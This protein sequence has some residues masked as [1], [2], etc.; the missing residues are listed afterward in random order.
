VLALAPPGASI[1]HSILSF[2]S[3]EGAE[4]PL[5]QLKI[6]MNNQFI[7]MST[8][9]TDL[10]D[11]VDH[12]HFTALPSKNQACLYELSHEVQDYLFE[13]EVCDP[14]TVMEIELQ[15]LCRPFLVSFIRHNQK[16]EEEKSEAEIISSS[17]IEEILGKL[18]SF[19]S[20]EATIEEEEEV[21][22]EEGG[23]GREL[24]RITRLR[25]LGI[26]E[27]LCE[28][29]HLTFDRSFNGEFTTIC[30]QCYQLIKLAVRGSSNKE[31]CAQWF[32]MFLE[33][34]LRPADD[35][36]AVDTLIEVI[37]GNAR[38]DEISSL[39]EHVEVL[40]RSIDN[41]RHER[42]LHILSAICATSRKL[43]STLKDLMQ[44]DAAF[45]M[46]LRNDTGIE[47]EVAEYQEWVKLSTF[48][49]KSQADDRGRLYELI[50][51]DI[52]DEGYSLAVSLACATDTHLEQELR[53]LFT[54]KSQLKLNK[55]AK[56]DLPKT[57]Y[58]YNEVTKEPSFPCSNSRLTKDLKTIKASIVNILGGTDYKLIK[59]ALSLCELMIQHG[60]YTSCA[61]L[62]LV[63]RAL[64]KRLSAFNGLDERPNEIYPPPKVKLN[65][66]ATSKDSPQRNS[67]DEVMI[68]TIH[69]II[70]TVYDIRTDALLSKILTKHKYSSSTTDNS[71][72]T[73]NSL[74]RLYKQKAK[75][76]ASTPG[77]SS[78]VAALNWMSDILQDDEL[79]QLQL[80]PEEVNVVMHDLAK[81]PKIVVPTLGKHFTQVPTLLRVMQEL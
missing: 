63:L 59:Q 53:D 33:H 4:S 67:E 34:G 32:P 61:E 69:S 42:P 9:L 78:Q 7:Q 73:E 12:R 24:V 70:S 36:K 17:R 29:L 15:M 80:N 20:D 26:I 43:R 22:E 72:P 77:A 38:L 1:E 66:V 18:V 31:Y 50:Q 51:A 64:V 68:K 46:N 71:I 45:T 75:F 40:I 44:S 6:K 27:L 41:E 39:S 35:F 65:Q 14:K 37:R 49:E 30:Q 74:S 13:I 56:L 11:K 79:V 28:I 58:S 3:R 21:E 19:C 23:R 47:I 57:S 8:T 5:K 25:E 60:F 62:S 55:H 81:H 76:V 2:E 52:Y 10:C 54:K 16:E 48:K